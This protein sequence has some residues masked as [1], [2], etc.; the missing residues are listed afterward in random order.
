MRMTCSV[1]VSYLTFYWTMCRVKSAADLQWI[2]QQ[3]TCINDTFGG[4][5]GVLSGICWTTW[6][7]NKL[8]VAKTKECWAFISVT[9]VGQKGKYHQGL[10][11][12][13]SSLRASW[14][15]RT[16]CP[17][18]TPYPHRDLV[19]AQQQEKKKNNPK[20]KKKKIKRQKDKPDDITSIFWCWSCFLPSSGTLARS[21]GG[22][23]MPNCSNSVHGDWQRGL[24]RVHSADDKYGPQVPCRRRKK[25]HKDPVPS[26]EGGVDRARRAIARRTRS[27]P[28]STR[29]PLG[30]LRSTPQ[31]QHKHQ[32][33]LKGAL[34]P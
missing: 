24:F 30:S 22:R 2:N 5:R 13:R 26:S 20:P 12:F 34:L 9:L 23:D 6:T 3:S 7:D 11:H 27:A 29:Q 16:S 33:V 28:V 21:R 14:E 19:F 18:P 32:P 10:G 8:L 25:P 1:Q 15:Q 31:S 17:E 4:P